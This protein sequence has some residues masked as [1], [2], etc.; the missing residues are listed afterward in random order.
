MKR[1]SFYV[2]L[3]VAS[4]A[5]TASVIFVAIYSVLSVPIGIAR[6][7]VSLEHFPYYTHCLAD[8]CWYALLVPVCLLAAGLLV[9]ARWKNKAVFE[10]TVGCQWLFALVWPLCGLLIWLLPQVPYVE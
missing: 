5:S 1:Q 2:R 10:L 9:L 3:L 7:H 4:A 8:Y 6:D